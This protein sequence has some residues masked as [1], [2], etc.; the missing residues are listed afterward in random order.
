M[1]LQKDITISYDK[2][3]N[4]NFIDY[5]NILI[6]MMNKND[7]NITNNLTVNNNLKLKLFILN[8][9][10]I[11]IKYK[12]NEKIKRF[13]IPINFNENKINS[14][15]EDIIN[16]GIISIKYISSKFSKKH[17]SF[18][19]EWLDNDKIFNYILSI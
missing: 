2:K 13:M 12:P 6:N 4:D 7:K 10:I 17:E 9:I 1:D 3:L 15:L 8:D 14:I 16:N 18:D 5:T 19:I 11:Q